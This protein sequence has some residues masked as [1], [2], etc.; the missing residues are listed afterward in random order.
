[1]CFGND[2]RR[3]GFFFFMVIIGKGGFL[4]ERSAVI[5]KE[6]VDFGLLGM[7]VTSIS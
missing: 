7:C 4:R 5:G 6:R 1:M 3:P 2:T